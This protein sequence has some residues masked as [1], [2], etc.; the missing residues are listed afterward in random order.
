MRPSVRKMAW[1]GETI[2]FATSA[3]EHT[4]QYVKPRANEYQTLPCSRAT[5][6][7]CRM[8]SSPVAPEVSGM[9]REPQPACWNTARGSN[10]DTGG[11][12]DG[13]ACRTA[14]V[15]TGATFVRVLAAGA[16]ATAGSANAAARRIGTHAAGAKVSA[17]P[18]TTRRRAQT[19]ARAENFSSAVGRPLPASERGEEL[20]VW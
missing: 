15:R 20:L 17:R 4:K 12:G 18:R 10:A 8:P 1:P 14:V 9:T 5:C 13:A 11:G 19:M 2:R 3:S 6:A 7:H 16:L